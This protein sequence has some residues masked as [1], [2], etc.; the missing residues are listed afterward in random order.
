MKDVRLYKP[1]FRGH[2]LL[3]IGRV[4]YITT[5]SNN[6][7]ILRKSYLGERDLA[8][9]SYFTRL[10]LYETPVGRELLLIKCPDI[11]NYL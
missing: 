4:V 10:S 6:M 8:D 9:T 2:L 11:K 7:S 1:L 3:L 5:Q